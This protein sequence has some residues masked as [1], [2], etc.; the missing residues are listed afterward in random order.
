VVK[1]IGLAGL[2]VLIVSGAFRLIGTRSRNGR[3]TTIRHFAPSRD[4]EPVPVVGMW[5]GSPGTMSYQYEV[6]VKRRTV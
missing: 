2:G 3:L 1:A 6:V 5:A 4:G